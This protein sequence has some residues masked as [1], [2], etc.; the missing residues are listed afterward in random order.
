MLFENS[1]MNIFA[2]V[3][4]WLKPSVT[5]KSVELKGYKIVRSDRCNKDKKRGGGVAFYIKSDMK[6]SVICKSERD[7]DVDYLF[8]KLIQSKLV[9]GVVYK[10][11]DIHVS[12]LDVIFNKITE[13]CSTEANILVMGDFNINMLA[14]DSLKTRSLV[15]HVNALSFKLIDS[16][17]S[18]HKPGCQPSLLDLL[19]GNC[20]T[21]I[22]NAYQ[23]SIGGIS[24]HDL[25]CVDYRFKNSKVKPEEY[26]GRDY[27]KINAESFVSDLQNCSFN[28]LY[29][30]SNANEKLKCF[31]ELLLST[32]DR[33]APLKKK[34]FK[35]PSCP[36]INK[37]INQIFSNRSEAYECW[38][39][40]KNNLRKWNN[41]KCLRNFANREMIRVKREYFTT[42]LN[43][44]LPT[45]QLWNNIKRLGL[46][47]TNT[48]MGGG[49]VNASTLN[50]YFVSHYVP[51]TFIENCDST[52]LQS[53]F[54]FRGVTNDEV[55][56]EFT[57]ASCDSVGVDLIPLKILKM[58]LPVTLP[59]ITNLINYCITCSQFPE[60]WK[61]AKV[62]PIGKVDNPT[63]TKDFRPISILC[64]IERLFEK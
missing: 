41:F 31:N 40:D 54:T 47:Q 29:Y 10:P 51:I 20:T 44:D 32:L 42:Q 1:K 3:E 38:K 57:S 58:S 39:K 22:S 26:W 5:N 18:C 63:T 52:E 59:Y 60:D 7:N 17:P 23:S 35:D 24:D 2:I 19:M 12:K 30:C 48:K 27:H 50:N 28:R 4:S 53:E 9:C 25:I 49:D 46:K 15:D 61:V 11:P 37:H 14:T 56:E 13:I 64:A 16:W 45:K 43:A 21:N 6:Y 62:I 8:I 33:H 34:T 55:L 36:W